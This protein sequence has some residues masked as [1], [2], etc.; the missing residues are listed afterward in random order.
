MRLVPK[1]AARLGKRGPA[2]GKQPEAL[3]LMIPLVQAEENAWVQIT[4]IDRGAEIRR[5]IQE[6]GIRP[7][8]QVQ[9]LHNSRGAV[10]LAKNNMRLGL[11]RGIGSH[12][13]VEPCPHPPA[14][15]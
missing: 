9:V 4:R 1:P 15:K 14:G 2:S 13:F 7:G 6:L 8:D 11:G 3:S 5:K 12:V 10:V